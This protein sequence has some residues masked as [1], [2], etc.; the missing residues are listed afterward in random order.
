MELLE[1]ITVFGSGLLARRHCLR[2]FSFC[3]RQKVERTW[4]W[5]CFPLVRQLVCMELVLVPLVG[6]LVVPIRYHQRVMGQRFDKMKV[7]KVKLRVV[8]SSLNQ[9]MEALRL[10]L[11]RSCLRRW[12]G[13]SLVILVLHQY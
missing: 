13:R 7:F 11:R 9:M 3:H 10:C 5:F 6:R 1:V 8:K 2:P 12:M 4:R